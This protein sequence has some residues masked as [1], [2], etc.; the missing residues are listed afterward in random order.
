MVRLFMSVDMVGSTDFKARL[1]GKGSDSWLKFFQD[2]FCNFP[3]MIAGQIGFEF[4]DD[5]STPAIRIWKAMGDEVLFV[6]TPATPA[7]MT[8]ILIAVLRT[9]RIYEDRYMTD[10]PLRLKG[11]AWL[12]DFDGHNIEIEIPELSSGDASAYQDFIGPDI[13]VGFRVTKF[14]RAGCMALSLDVAEQVLQA[15]NA[16]AAAL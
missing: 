16:S 10:L 4:L 5:E 1:T 12:A 11:T 3:L 15:A 2:F 7:E 8:S 6:A 13:D 14:A 9:M